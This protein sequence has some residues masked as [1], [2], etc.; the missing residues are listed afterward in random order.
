MI[1]KPGKPS[2]RMESMTRLAL[3]TW[4]FLHAATTSFT[5]FTS[6]APATAVISFPVSV[7]VPKSLAADCNSVIAL[8]MSPPECVEHAW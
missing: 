7:S 1:C 4:F 2:L 6:T 5:A 3:S 8:R